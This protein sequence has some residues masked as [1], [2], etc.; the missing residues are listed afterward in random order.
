[1]DF[2]GDYDE[3]KNQNKFEN[4][5]FDT[6]DPDFIQEIIDENEDII[7]KHGKSRVPS[8]VIILDDCLDYLRQNPNNNIIS[9]LFFKGRHLNLSCIVL[10]QKL[11][12]I[13]T[14]LRINTRYCIFL[15]VEILK[16]W[17]ICLRNL[18]AKE[19]GN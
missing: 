2:S 7:R 3:F 14:L 18:R 17:I 13:G 9:K 8:T 4:R 6:Y 12:G 19:K 16:K 5:M 11:R 15:D 1:M 10:V